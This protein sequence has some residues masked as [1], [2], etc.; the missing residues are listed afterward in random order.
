M[1]RLGL[2]RCPSQGKR[3]LSL[4]FYIL[5]IY[6]VLSIT[7]VSSAF[8]QAAPGRWIYGVLIDCSD[9]M[10]REM[11]DANG[12]PSTVGKVAKSIIFDQF[13]QANANLAT[14]TSNAML[15]PNLRD[16]TIPDSLMLFVR[17]LGGVRDQEARSCSIDDDYYSFDS[18][19]GGCMLSDWRRQPDEGESALAR[20]GSAWRGTGPSV[21]G[22]DSDHSIVGVGL[23]EFLRDALAIPGTG[24]KLLFVTDGGDSCSRDSSS[25]HLNVQTAVE[26][27]NDF[28]TAEHYGSNIA[29]TI[30]GFGVTDQQAED[31]LL[32][33]GRTIKNKGA[34]YSHVTIAPTDPANARYRLTSEIQR[35]ISAGEM[36]YRLYSPCKSCYPTRQNNCDCCFFANLWRQQCAF[37]EC[38]PWDGDPQWECMHYKII[39]YTDSTGPHSYTICDKWEQF[40]CPDKRHS[41]TIWCGNAHHTCGTDVGTSGE[42]AMDPCQFCK[43]IKGVRTTYNPNPRYQPGAAITAIFAGRNY[44]DGNPSCFGSA[45]CG[46]S[47]TPFATIP[48]DPA[49]VND[50]WPREHRGERTSTQFAPTVNYPAVPAEGGWR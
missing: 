40:W 17:N 2:T 41:D 5:S 33:L 8:A 28:L 39:T 26:I 43:A 44:T 11:P 21:G 37:P 1:Y 22:P 48:L 20:F 15:D 46:L 7:Y 36:N 50:Q 10:N 35:F 23:V 24:I 31:R 32:N 4:Y 13:F 19:D 18:T 47:Y 6:F 42:C 25:N 49:V 16:L 27:L 9:G 45:G 38:D 3:P 34:K 29:L 30:V 14:G 12:N